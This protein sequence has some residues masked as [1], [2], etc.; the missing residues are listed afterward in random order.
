MNSAAVYYTRILVFFHEYV[1]TRMCSL[2]IIIISSR[3]I[4][5]Q[6]PYIHKVFPENKNW[7]YACNSDCA[8]LFMIFSVHSISTQRRHNDPG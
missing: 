5:N 7:N 4:Y 8:L 1:C 2:Y 6:Q 3:T